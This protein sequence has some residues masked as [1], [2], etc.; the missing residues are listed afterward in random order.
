MNILSEND[1]KVFID[2]VSHF[3]TELTGEPAL[4]RTAYLADT[5]VPRFDYTGLI[6]LS[7]SFRGCVYFSAPQKLIRSLLIK[8]REPLDSEENLLDTVGEIANTI[9]GNARKHFGNG[10]E[11]SV[12]VTIKGA[13]DQIKSST[14][15]RPYAICLNW[16][17]HEAVVVVDIEPT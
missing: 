7:G 11:I 3:F 16:Q 6:T 14:R 10:L 9:S 17:R 12:P 15:A 5:D 4:V 1:L 8:L 13:T 2:A